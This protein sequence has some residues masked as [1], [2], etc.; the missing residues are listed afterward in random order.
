MDFFKRCKRLFQGRLNR[1]SLIICSFLLGVV[2][3]SGIFLISF[4]I[5]YSPIAPVTDALYYPLEYGWLGL[6]IIVDFSLFVRRL[7]DFGRSGFWSLLYVVPLVNVIVSL[8]LLFYPGDKKANKYG[9][10]P[11]PRIEI[12][13]SFGLS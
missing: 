6:V 7:H 10:P 5:R 2:C 9:M 11:E 12:K 8:F 4:L 13:G 3:V 1:R